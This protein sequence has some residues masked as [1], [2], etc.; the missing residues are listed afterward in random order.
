MT[1]PAAAERRKAKRARPAWRPRAVVTDVDGTLTAKSRLMDLQAIEALRAAEAGG[2]PVVLATGNVLPIVYALAY[3]IGTSGPVVAEN[4]GLVYFQ[5]KLLTLTDPRPARKAHRAVSRATDA[6]RLFTDRWRVT[7][8]AY[9]ERPRTLAKVRRALRSEGLDRSVRVERTGFAVHLMDPTHSKFEGVRR[10]LALIGVDPADALAIGD[11]DNDR[12]MLA[13]C[14]VGVAVGDAS[15]ALKRVADF[16]AKEPMGAGIWEALTRY[17]VVSRR[18]A[19]RRPASRAG[20]GRA[21]GPRTTAAARGGRGRP[22]RARRKPSA[23][24]RRPP[25]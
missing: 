12:S 11:S 14:G 2:T 1:V 13:G 8:V 22:T 18:P 23:P 3:F 24:A 4:G 25:R 6:E 16:V 7:E 20:D 19:S 9:V 21:G 15:P 17:G 5:G 10:A